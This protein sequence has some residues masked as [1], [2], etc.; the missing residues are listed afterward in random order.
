MGKKKPKTKE[1]NGVLTAFIILFVLVGASI[2]MSSGNVEERKF[3]CDDIGILQL[4]VEELSHASKLADEIQGVVYIPEK[5]QMIARTE[6]LDC[7][8]FEYYKEH[9]FGGFR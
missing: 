5:Q 3:D 8:N 2:F 6:L 7:D 4:R 1:E 9:L